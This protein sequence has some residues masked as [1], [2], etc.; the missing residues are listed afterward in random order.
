MFTDQTGKLPHASSRGNNHQMV[1]HEIDKESTLV[2]PMKNWAEGK[3][4][5]VQRQAL[6]QMQ[7][8]GIVPKH[9]VLENKIST[10]YKAEILSADTTYQLVPPDDHRRNISEKDIQAWKDHFVC[11]LS[12]KAAAFTMHLWFQAIPQDKQQVL[13]LR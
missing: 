7:L 8:Q 10:A 3:T 5:L 13:L 1:V 4:I 9:Q 12:G 6:N 2:N 11:V